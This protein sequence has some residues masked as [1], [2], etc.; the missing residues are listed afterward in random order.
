MRLVKYIATLASCQR[1]QNLSPTKV[2]EFFQILLLAP[3]LSN[4]YVGKCSCSKVVSRVSIMSG[5]HLKGEMCCT[6]FLFV[7]LAFIATR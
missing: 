3:N 1:V 7:E 6:V 4:L 2:W 5:I